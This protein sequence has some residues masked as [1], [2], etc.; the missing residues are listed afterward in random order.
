MKP[1]LISCIPLLALAAFQCSAAEEVMSVP[2]VPAQANAAA[3]P[4]PAAGVRA[5]EQALRN[6]RDPATDKVTVASHAS[7]II[8]TGKVDSQE[9][10][11]RIQT[12]ATT[13]AAGMRVSSQIEVNEAKDEA[14]QQ[15]SSALIRDV[16]SALRR[17]SATASLRVL[18]ALDDDQG[19]VLSGPVPSRQAQVAAE[20]V[21]KRVPGVRHVDNRLTVPE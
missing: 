14:T 3:D 6:S 10:A 11:D 5:V 21:A 18:I 4:D 15:A 12:T 9:E 20:R 19:I 16:E 8:L 7:T 17:D 1:I 13:A 2:Q